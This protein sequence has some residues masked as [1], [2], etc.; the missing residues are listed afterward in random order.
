[1]QG[2]EQPER[3]LSKADI[4][5]LLAAP[6]V[7]PRFGAE[8]VTPDLQFIEDISE[9][10]T[11]GSITRNMAG[12]VH[13][14]CDLELTRELAWGKARIRIYCEIGPARWDL[15]VYLLT[16]P[17]DPHG[18]TPKTYKV[19]GYDALSHLQRLIGDSKT[20]ASGITVVTAMEQIV[21]DSG[22]G[23][24]IRIDSDA[25]GATL[26]SAITW[27]SMVAGSGTQPTWLLALTDLAGV[28]SYRPPW[29]NGK[30]ELR[31][32]LYRPDDL[33]EPE[34]T[35][36]VDDL[37]EGVVE[38]TYTNTADTWGQPNRWFFY[39]N[40]QSALVEGITLYVKNNLDVGPSSQLSIG[41]N[42]APPIGLDVYDYAS[43]VRQGDQLAAKQIHATE[44][45]DADLGTFPALWHDD[46][47]L[48]VDDRGSRKVKGVSWTMPIGTGPVKTRW[49]VIG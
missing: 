21:T 31:S 16:T 23:A 18:E 6:V 36:T 7:R 34:W 19:K 14:A 10:L 40:R 32:G 33:R 35:F 26:P 15:G 44:Y 13:G 22:V 39:M 20:L 4:R 9:D 5:A 41:L 1:M 11:G 45:I 49:E 48:W 30:G 25:A 38:P 8:L 3:N 17:A 29:A 24:P 2:L 27:P 12:P 42:P 43:L 47:G 28:I 46:I 37:A